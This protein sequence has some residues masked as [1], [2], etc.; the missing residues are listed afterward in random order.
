MFN[1]KLYQI[2]PLGGEKRTAGGGQG[3]VLGDFFFQD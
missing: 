1:F 2:Y 3:V